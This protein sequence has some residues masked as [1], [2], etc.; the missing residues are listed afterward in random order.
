VAD[1]A[2]APASTPIAARDGSDSSE[3]AAQYCRNV[4]DAIADARFARQKAMLAAMEK[5]LEARLKQLEAKRADYQDWLQRRETFL[6]KADENLVAVM[7]QMRPDA[8]AQQIAAMNEDMAAALLSKLSPRVAS[9]ILN[10]IE[11]AR[12]ARLTSTMVG[13]SRRLQEGRQG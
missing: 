3:N 2:P 6:K 10:E 5:D 1:P 13:L 8:A 11:P 9:S 7:S 4:A 12:A